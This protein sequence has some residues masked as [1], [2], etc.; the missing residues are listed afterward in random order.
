VCPADF[1]VTAIVEVIWMSTASRTTVSAQPASTSQTAEVEAFLSSTSPVPTPAARHW[2]LR[3]APWLRNDP[4]RGRMLLAIRVVHSAIFFGE[5]ASV[6]YLLYAG[7]RKQ[8]S[9]AAAVAAG[10]IAAESVIYFANGQ[11]CPL[12]D[13]AEELGADHIS[14]TDVYLPR[15]IAMRIF[16]YN[17][18]LVVLATLLH[19]RVF[20]TKQPAGSRRA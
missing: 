5:E 13:L 16:T 11:R 1:I 19:A 2:A 7:L 20:L 9:R 8:Q 3:M 15:W 14:V 4:W 12:S 6:G 10:A 17:A 18:P